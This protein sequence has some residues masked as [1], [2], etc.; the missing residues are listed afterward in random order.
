MSDLNA[1]ATLVY[2]TAIDATD[3]QAETLSALSYAFVL[4]AK[5]FGLSEEATADGFRL[6]WK[7][8]DPAAAVWEDGP[9]QK[10]NGN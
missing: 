4:A 9:C 3:D 7:T 10:S 5:A 8:V 6:A 2:N 1:A